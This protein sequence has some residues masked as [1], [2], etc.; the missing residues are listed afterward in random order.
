[1]Y[2]AIIEIVHA[3]WK[4]GIS[5]SALGMA[6]FAV[7]KT[8]AFKRKLKRYFPW[9]MEQ[10]SEVKEYINNQHLIMRKLGIEWNGQENQTKNIPMNLPKSYQLSWGAM[11]MKDY[12]RKL[13]SRKFQVL[14]G[15]LAING[16]SIYLFLTGVVD[17]DPEINKWMPIINL[18][19]GSVTNIVYLVVEGSADKANIGRGKNNDDGMDFTQDTSI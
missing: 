16:L 11:K 8:K 5:L 14:L 6:I 12:L 18:I 15:S 9:L 7:L 2:D 17:I 4:N 19:V 13:G 3:F 1:M 10:D